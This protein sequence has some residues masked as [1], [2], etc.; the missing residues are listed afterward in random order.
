MRNPRGRNHEMARL[1]IRM[2]NR[3]LDF[4]LFHVSKFLGY[5]Y[6]SA[7]RI[8]HGNDCARELIH[9]NAHHILKYELYTRDFW[10]KF[11]KLKPLLG[12]LIDVILGDVPDILIQ[13]FWEDTKWEHS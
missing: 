3:S 1:L 2:F 13:F 6:E 8:K 7:P 10:L 9:I 5:V 12:C 11:F 4:P